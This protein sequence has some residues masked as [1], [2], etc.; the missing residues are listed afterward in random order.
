MKDQIIN[1][2]TAIIAHN[3]GFNVDT[4][5]Y[6]CNYYSNHHNLL[7]NDNIIKLDDFVYAKW[8][9]LNKESLSGIGFSNCEFNAPTQSLLQKWLREVHKI[10]LWYGILDNPNRYHVEDIVCIDTNYRISGINKGSKTY[11]EALELGLQE[12]LNFILNERSNN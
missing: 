12:A 10:D 4:D 3:A 2:N 1:F 5:V 6:W 8:K 11:E 9:L 7:N